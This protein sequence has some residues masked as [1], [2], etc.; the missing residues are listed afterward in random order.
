MELF[1]VAIE[2]AGDRGL[3]LFSGVKDIHEAAFIASKWLHYVK[4]LG[5]KDTDITNWCNMLIEGNIM[6]DDTS[7][8]TQLNNLLAL[9]IALASPLTAG[10]G[11]TVNIT[12]SDFQSLYYGMEL[13]PILASK[14]SKDSTSLLKMYYRSG[15]DFLSRV[16]LMNSIENLGYQEKELSFPMPPTKTQFK[17][18]ISFLDDSRFERRKISS[19][20]EDARRSSSVDQTIN[21]WSGYLQTL[22]TVEKELLRTRAL[23]EGLRNV[24]TKSCGAFVGFILGSVLPDILNVKELETTAQVVGVASGWFIAGVL[25]K[26]ITSPN[27]KAKMRAKIR[28]MQTWQDLQGWGKI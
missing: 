3:S 2:N 13:F 11:G 21:S 7:T 6:S 12:R 19:F 4:E 16:G 20:I 22:S 23:H 28:L 26:L 25:N 18:Y 17:N 9:Y 24:G 8:I 14:T 10:Y 1:K 5:A 15:L 27:P